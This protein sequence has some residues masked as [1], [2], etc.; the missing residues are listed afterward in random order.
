MTS[1]LETYTLIKNTNMHGS[2]KHPTNTFIHA[3]KVEKP[4]TGTIKIR[5][6]G[7]I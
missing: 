4:N 3:T 1:S 7:M 2:K 5:R 6:N